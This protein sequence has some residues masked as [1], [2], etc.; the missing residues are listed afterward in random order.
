MGLIGLEDF[1]GFIDSLQGLS[2]LQSDAAD[3]RTDDSFP[4]LGLYLVHLS[5]LH[6]ILRLVKLEVLQIKQQQLPVSL[7]DDGCIGVQPNR[8]L[9]MVGS[10]LAMAEFQLA[11]SVVVVQFRAFGLAGQ[12]TQHR[13]ALLGPLHAIQ[14]DGY[15][16]I[17]LSLHLVLA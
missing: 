11:Q 9:K 12:G 2:E 3:E 15:F 5:Q 17:Y 4:V 8:I 7:L 14:A 6:H 16:Q 13:D 1:V 10:F